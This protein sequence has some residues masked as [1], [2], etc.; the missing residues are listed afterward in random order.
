VLG[1]H[2]YTILTLS[3]YTLLSSHSNRL[4]ISFCISSSPPF[5]SQHQPRVITLPIPPKFQPLLDLTA[6][7]IGSHKRT[8]GSRLLC[9]SPK[10]SLHTVR[11]R[12]VAQTSGDVDY[13]AFRAYQKDKTK[14]ERVLKVDWDD[15][16]E[17][18]AEEGWDEDWSD[19]DDDVEEKGKSKSKYMDGRWAWLSTFGLRFGIAL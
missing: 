3:D 6:F 7:T 15:E 11:V 12:T 10:G 17:Q 2:L 13:V 14:F 9:R 4:L 18:I 8:R 5:C 1:N 19:I 16:V